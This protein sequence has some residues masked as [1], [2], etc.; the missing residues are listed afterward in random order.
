MREFIWR[1]RFAIYLWR[2]GIPWTLARDDAWAGDYDPSYTPEG[3]AADELSYFAD[4][5]E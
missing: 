5:P 3:A 2:H 4:D 1:F